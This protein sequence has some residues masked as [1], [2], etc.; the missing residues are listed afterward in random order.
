MF[1]FLQ[2]LSVSYRIEN[3]YTVSL[4]IDTYRIVWWPYRLI[5]NQVVINNLIQLS[6]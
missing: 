4:R 3:N 1:E 6:C 2:L 5:P